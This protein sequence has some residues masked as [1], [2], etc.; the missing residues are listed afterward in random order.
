MDKM[1]EAMVAMIPRIAPHF[2]SVMAAKNVE[3][4]EA[5][6]RVKVLAMF[7]MVQGARMMEPALRV[8]VV[9]VAEESEEG[10]SSTVA[11]I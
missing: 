2:S 1:I 9:I 7:F 4:H 11:R 3:N 10:T 5:R 8:V 6:L